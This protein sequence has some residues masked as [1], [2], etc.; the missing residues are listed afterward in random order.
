MLANQAASSFCPLLSR[1]SFWQAWGVEVG[2]SDRAWTALLM[3]SSRNRERDGMRCLPGRLVSWGRTAILT[4]Q[5]P[6]LMLHGG[7]GKDKHNDSSGQKKVASSARWPTPL[8]QHSGGTS[9]QICEF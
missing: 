6:K 9:R 8:S 7:T 1:R 3:H 4:L 2:D 5:T